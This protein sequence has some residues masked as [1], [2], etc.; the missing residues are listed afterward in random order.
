MLTCDQE[1]RLK[2]RRWTDGLLEWHSKHGPGATIQEQFG[3][4]LIVS[5]G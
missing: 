1:E 3:D 5:A 4:E 2:H